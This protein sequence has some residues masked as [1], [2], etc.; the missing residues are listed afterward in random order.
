MLGGAANFACEYATKRY[1]SNCINWGMLPFLVEDPS[2]FELGDC[3]YLPACARLC[4]KLPIPCP[5]WL[6]SPMAV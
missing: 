4:W 2:V 6:L 5:P 1:R 3:I